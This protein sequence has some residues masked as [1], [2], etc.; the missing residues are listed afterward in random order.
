MNH[1]P[2]NKRKNQKGVKVTNPEDLTLK[3][4]PE[5]SLP[6]ARRE[7]KK[8]ATWPSLS[9]VRGTKKRGVELRNFDQER[10]PSGP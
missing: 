8:G 2:V 1:C 10:N 7:K 4:P 9:R 6:A 3:T 5:F